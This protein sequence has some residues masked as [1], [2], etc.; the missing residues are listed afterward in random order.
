MYQRIDVDVVPP[1][2]NFIKNKTPALFFRGGGGGGG[3]L[4]SFSAYIFVKKQ[5]CGNGVSL[6]ILQSI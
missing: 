3:I 1:V 2:C 5:G 6:W 4:G